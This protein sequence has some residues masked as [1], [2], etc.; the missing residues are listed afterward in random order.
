MLLAEIPKSGSIA[1]RSLMRPVIFA[2]TAISVI[3]GAGQT[4][5]AA[6]PLTYADAA[7]FYPETGL[8]YAEPRLVQTVRFTDYKSGPVKE[9]LKTKG[10]ILKQDAQQPEFIELDANHKGL[11]LEAKQKAFGIML[12]NSLKLGGFTEVEIDWGV[13]K[14]PSGASYEQGLLNEGVAVQ[15]FLGEETVPSG[16]MF[17]PDT[18]YFISLFLC[19]GNDRKHYP[20]VGSYWKDSGRYV[21]ADRP[22]RGKM[23]T[24]RFNLVNAY[25][26]YFGKWDDLDPKVTGIG[27]SLDTTDSSEGGK[28]EAF[29]REIRFYK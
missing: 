13:E 3:V 15:F 5:R 12:N 10:F 29:V 18:P 26:S 22:D 14:F 8:S 6:D 21:C 1:E 2:L 7:L 25:R 20:Y 19:R 11:V 24:S 9:W 23:V 27:L 4:A 16:A 17:V 28:S